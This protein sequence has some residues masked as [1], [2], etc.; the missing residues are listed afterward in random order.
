V[1]PNSVAARARLTGPLSL[2]EANAVCL[3]L[4]AYVLELE[5]RILNADTET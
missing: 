4:S 2:A 1:N 3:K 5:A